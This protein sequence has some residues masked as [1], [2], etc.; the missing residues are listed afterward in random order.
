M[1]A[2][3]RRALS[4]R[5]QRGS[6]VWGPREPAVGFRSVRCEN[7]DARDDGHGPEHRT[8]RLDRRG[9]RP[10]VE[11]TVRLGCVSAT[12]VD[13]RSDCEGDRHSQVRSDLGTPQRENRSPQRHRPRPRRAESDRSG[14]QGIVP[15]RGRRGIPLGRETATAGIRGGH[16]PILEREAGGGLP[17][18]Q[19][20]PAHA[21]DR[22][23]HPDDGV[24][25]HGAR[26][27]D[28]GCVHPEPSD[29]RERTVWGIP[30]E[31]PGGGR[32]RG[33]PNPDESRGASRQLPGDLR[34]PLTRRGAA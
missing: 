18:L 17:D 1:E 12:L 21:R 20:D 11:R 24:R 26:L 16:L 5:V 29:G 15:P 9:S 6:S 32:R 13:V 14:F 19:Q 30:P 31:R 4:G 33:N 23:E 28:G 7:L 34:R 22:R 10:D 27:R 2:G 25:Q 8:E 3:R